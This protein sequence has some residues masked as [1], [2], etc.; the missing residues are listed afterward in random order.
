MI[1]IL[2][3]LKIQ[4]MM[5][6]RLLNCVPCEPV[7]QHGLRATVFACQ[8]GLHAN[9][10]VSQ[11]VKAFQLLI[12]Y[13]HANKCAHVPY[14]VPMCHQ[15]RDNFPTWCAK[16]QKDMPIFQTFLLRNAKEISILLLLH[17]KSNIILDN[18]YTYHMYMY[19]T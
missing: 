16:M 8:H 13:Q 11:R 15:R 3:L 12:M 2:I 19:H 14:D 1:K 4:S 17:N 9:V 5:D 10:P 7:F 6:M 18:S